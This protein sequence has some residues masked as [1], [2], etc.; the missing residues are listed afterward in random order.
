MMLPWR[1][2]WLRW[3]GLLL[4]PTGALS[5]YTGPHH[6]CGRPLQPPRYLHLLPHCLHHTHHLNEDV[7]ESLE[8]LGVVEY[9]AVI[10]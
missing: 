7:N 3:V 9:S 8:L 10:Y 1:V 6:P 5:A 4:L 2:W